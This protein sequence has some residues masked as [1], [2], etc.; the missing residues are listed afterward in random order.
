MVHKRCN[1]DEI[2][3]ILRERAPSR[4]ARNHTMKKNLNT[5]LEAVA[6]SAALV[7]LPSCGDDDD[8][9]DNPSTSTAATGTTAGCPTAGCPTAGCP[10]G[11][12]AGCPT[13]ATADCATAGC[14]TAGCATA[15]DSTAGDST[16]GSESGTGGGSGTAG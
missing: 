3:G 4:C 1:R 10:T 9:A 5:V 13:G 15:G 11:A 16:A 8:T 14:A 12:T 2:V 7:A 6:L